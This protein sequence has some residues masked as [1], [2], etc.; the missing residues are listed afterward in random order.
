MINQQNNFWWGKINGILRLLMNHTASG[1]LPLYIVNEY[2]KS[3]GSWLG[4]MLADSL[5]VPFPRNRLPMFCSS[6]MHGHYMWKGNMKNI[7]VIWRDGRDVLVSQYY[8]SLFYNDVGVSRGVDI[9]RKK[10]YFKNYENI[11]EN[12]PAFIEYTFKNKGNLGF[13]WTDFY[14]VWAS[15][16]N[17]IHTK[18]EDLRLNTAAE[19]RRIL[20]L[21]TGKEFDIKKLENIAD[22]Y[23]FERQ[24]GRKPGQENTSSFMRKGIIGDWKNNF[25]FDAKKTFS[26]YAGEALVGLRYEK[27]NSWVRNS[28]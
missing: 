9:T 6:I 26:R 22:K 3:G 1:F 28:H 17:I 12:L 11:Q 21:L 18:Y 7:V 8:H 15:K 14:N 2:P 27:D 5:E 10:V 19:L 23:S 16:N 20:N 4:Q 25:T 24:S 13:S